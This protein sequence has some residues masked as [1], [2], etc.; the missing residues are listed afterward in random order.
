V[1][2]EGLDQQGLGQKPA[3]KKLKKDAKTVIRSHGR[4]TAPPFTLISTGPSDDRH[5]NYFCFLEDGV[6]QVDHL[7][8]NRHV[9]QGSCGNRNPLI[10]A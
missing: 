10:V 7:V 8:D 6:C 1:Q 2:K 5:S 3:Y 4:Y 9:A